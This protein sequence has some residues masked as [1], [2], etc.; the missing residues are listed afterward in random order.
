MILEALYET[1][2]EFQEYVDRYAAHYIEGRSISV[3][4]ALTHKIVAHYA[5]WLL[6]K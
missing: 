5:A 2:K 4:E 3:A 6:K 1:N